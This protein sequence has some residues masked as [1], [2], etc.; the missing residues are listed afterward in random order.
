VNADHLST[1]KIML[2]S[3]THLG[4]GVS[5]VAISSFLN[6]EMKLGGWP[7]SSIAFYLGIPVLF[8]LIRL[9]FAHY[10]DAKGILRRS[11]LLGLITSL[12]G[13]I[14]I[15]QAILP[16]EN[17]LILIGASAFYFGSSILTTLVD[18]NATIISSDEDRSRVAGVIQTFR[19]IGFAL[20]G[21]LGSIL[22]RSLDFQ[23]FILIIAGF[24]A[25]VGIISIISVV[26]STN[27]DSDTPSLLSNLGKLPL[28]LT[29]ASPRLMVLF[30][31][32]YPIGLFMQDL[33]L[34]PFAIDVLGF[35]R[36][37][38]GQLVAVWTTLTLIFVPIGVILAN[39]RGRLLPI[40]TGELMSFIGLILF[41]LTPAIPNVQLFY[42]G[43]IL[44]GMG[45]GIASAP[46]IGMMLDVSASFPGQVALLLGFFGIMTTAGRSLAAV[47]AGVVLLLTSD[48][49]QLLFLIEA[50]VVIFGLIP[51]LLLDPILRNVDVGP[52]DPIQASVIDLS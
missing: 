52:V 8:E 39:R 3:A 40:V 30:L 9:P 49:Y 46:A 27:L 29:Q 51:L 4:V 35:Q 7:S 44:F 20:G 28:L 37:N 34:E 41:A 24:Y 16:V 21:V 11:L 15:P 14:L 47:M 50:I 5:I 2:I 18:A 25:V 45:N 10:Y 13:L 22:Y 48:S 31:I 42:T 26:P 12:G 43:L 33:V 17:Y 38:V 36:G 32:L 23:L 19:L 1:F 6:A